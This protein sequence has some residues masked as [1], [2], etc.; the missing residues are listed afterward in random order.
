VPYGAAS[1]AAA[2]GSSGLLPFYY[3]PMLVEEAAPVLD[4]R[5]RLAKSASQGARMVCLL[6]ALFNFPSVH[7]YF[8]K[9]FVSSIDQLFVT[10][11]FCRR[12]SASNNFHIR[13]IP[14]LTCPEMSPTFGTSVDE[15]AV[16]LT[17]SYL[18]VSKLK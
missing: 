7:L 15:A 3:E 14:S 8:G 6:L 10:C 17:S 4:A 13:D 18:S 1:A 12:V 5:P 2:A 11:L 9:L 16:H